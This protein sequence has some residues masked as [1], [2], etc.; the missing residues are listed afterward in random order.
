MAII[1]KALAKAIGG[2]YDKLFFGS[3]MRVVH[4]LLGGEIVREEGR[5]TNHKKILAKMATAE[6]VY[7][8]GHKNMIYPGGLP[9]NVD[10]KWTDH[11]TGSPPKLVKSMEWTSTYFIMARWEQPVHGLLSGQDYTVFAFEHLM[12]KCSEGGSTTRRVYAV[13]LRSPWAKDKE[14][15]QE[16]KDL[17]KQHEA[18]K[19]MGKGMWTGDLKP[20]DPL[21]ECRVFREKWHGVIRSANG[22]RDWKELDKYQD[23]KVFKFSFDL[24]TLP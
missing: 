17:H 23:N 13:Q 22:E 14:G 2:S 8:W 11:L 19:T 1:I 15:M 21:W 24:S 9:D 16:Q 10:M 4:W 3:A 12:F 18:V 6:H 20:S 5:V 7:E